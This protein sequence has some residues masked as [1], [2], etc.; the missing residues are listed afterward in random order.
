MVYTFKLH[1]YENVCSSVNWAKL[2]SNVHIEDL[3]SVEHDPG[4][5]S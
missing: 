3:L 2:T 1:K 5:S 4:G